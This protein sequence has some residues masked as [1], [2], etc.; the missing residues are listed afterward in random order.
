MRAY[1]SFVVL[2]FFLV[3][4]VQAA[5]PL[6]GVG[7]WQA[8]GPAKMRLVAGQ[9]PGGVT[10]L[11]V[12]N[13]F[14]DGWRTYWKYPGG[15]GIEPVFDWAG[16]ANFKAQTPM[17]E[18]PLRFTDP[19]GDYFGYEAGTLISIPVRMM[20]TRL[21]PD[22]EPYLAEDGTTKIVPPPLRWE[23]AIIYTGTPL[24]PGDVLD[25]R[26]SV[27]IGVCQT[28]CLPLTFEFAGAVSQGQLASNQFQPVFDGHIKALPKP[29]GE[30]LQIDNL[31]FDG[32][33][34]N[35]VV[36]GQQLLDPEII[37]LA[38]GPLDAFEALSISAAM[39]SLI[40]SAFPLG[41]VLTPRL[42]GVTLR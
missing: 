41:P 13:D 35:M 28:V 32:V 2:S 3:Q 17:F 34:L 15:S 33:S 20:Q 10:A 19:A 4:S 24:Q 27:D 1:F 5:K 9:L 39:R 7:E 42:S 21:R 38:G 14:Y 23:E 8:Q 18:T 26:L 36:L 12:G 31:T 30:A 11:G 6:P 16:S 40:W 37:A 22:P 25:V 29:P